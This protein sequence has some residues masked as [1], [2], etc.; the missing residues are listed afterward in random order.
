M[1]YDT[2]IYFQKKTEGKYNTETGDYDDDLVEEK[3]IYGAVSN[4]SMEMMNIVYG[5]INQTS[6][7]VHLQNHYEDS[8]DNIRINQKVYK[9]DNRTKYKFKESLVLSE[10]K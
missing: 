5:Q 2:P 3:E 7:T 6:L 1:R 8:F 9:V 10:V 4:T